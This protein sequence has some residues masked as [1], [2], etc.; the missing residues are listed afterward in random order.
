MAHLFV[1]FNPREQ[2]R[3][4]FGMLGNVHIRFLAES[5]MRRYF[6]SVNMKPPLAAI[7]LA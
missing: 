6:I 5:E 4:I 2:F 1:S 3:G 7:S